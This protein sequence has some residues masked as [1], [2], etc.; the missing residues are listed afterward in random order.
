M[1][2]V[3]EIVARPTPP[4]WT[5]TVGATGVAYTKMLVEDDSRPQEYVVVTRRLPVPVVT[6]MVVPEVEAVMVLMPVVVNEK[7]VLA[8]PPLAVTDLLATPVAEKVT[9][10]RLEVLGATVEP[11][12]AFAPDTRK[13]TDVPVF[14]LEAEF[15]IVSAVPGGYACAAGTKAT[16]AP[17]TDVAAR[18]A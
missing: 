7:V 11:L 16:E 10:Q 12:A 5:V 15:E 4:V 18:A 2:A 8:A 17:S 3:H 13:V 6:V 1:S 14:A 9:G